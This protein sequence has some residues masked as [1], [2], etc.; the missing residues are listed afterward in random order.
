MSSPAAASDASPAPAAAA[1]APAAAA[2]AALEMSPDIQAKY[3]CVRS[4]GEE[5]VSESELKAL[6]VKKVGEMGSTFNLCAP[7]APLALPP[8][9]FCNIFL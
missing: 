9:Q 1:A 7:H 2:A 4:V 3:D 5:C 6:L 8:L